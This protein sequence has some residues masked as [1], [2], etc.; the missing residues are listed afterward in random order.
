MESVSLKIRKPWIDLSKIILIYLMIACHLGMSEITD[1]IIV[2]FHMSAFF[3]IS[4]Y[5]E[6]ENGGQL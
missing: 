3:I 2:S 1:T 4:G 6:V 5:T